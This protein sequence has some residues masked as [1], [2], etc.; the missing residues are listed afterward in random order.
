MVEASG[1]RTVANKMQKLIKMRNKKKAIAKTAI[2][3]LAGIKL[4][5]E[6]SSALTHTLSNWQH[7]RMK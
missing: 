5:K 1:S 7:M 2:H 3:W 4:T 6:K